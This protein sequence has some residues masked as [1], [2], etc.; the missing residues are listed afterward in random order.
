MMEN[1]KKG[2]EMDMVCVS[3]FY[4]GKYTFN[5]GSYYEGTFK[6]DTLHGR[7]TYFWN[8]KRMYD[9][10]WKDNRM[11]G[12]GLLYDSG[13]F[14]IGYF[15]NDKRNGKGLYIHNEKKS[16]VGNLINN[17]LVDGYCLIMNKSG[18]E[19]C[20]FFKDNKIK[21]EENMNNKELEDYKE[22]RNFYNENIDLIKKY[23]FNG[24]FFK[25]DRF[26]NK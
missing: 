23:N 7:G 17:E 21:D 2:R 19:F 13:K 15:E 3:F 10:E 9:G 26:P 12:F 25:F 5:Y 8:E 4:L 14:Y 11:H 18:E 16:F 22:L 6:E 1:S 20:Q 24:Q